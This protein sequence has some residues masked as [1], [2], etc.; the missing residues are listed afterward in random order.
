MIEVT[1]IGNKINIVWA[2][3]GNTY[4]TKSIMYNGVI[5]NNV[6]V[7]NYTRGDYSGFYI[8]NG[9]LRFNSYYGNV[10]GTLNLDWAFNTT[11]NKETTMSQIDKEELSNISCSSEDIFRN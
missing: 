6:Y 9:N 8:S 11:Y 10:I 2:T 7:K 4:P 5:Q 3:T 1:V